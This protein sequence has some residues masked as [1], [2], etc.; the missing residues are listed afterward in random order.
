[1]E[2]RGQKRGEICCPRATHVPIWLVIYAKQHFTWRRGPCNGVVRFHGTATTFTTFQRNQ[3]NVMLISYIKLECY[4]TCLG[5]NGKFCKL[6]IGLKFHVWRV[7]QQLDVEP[8]ILLVINCFDCNN[9]QK[10]SRE[11]QDKKRFISQNNSSSG[12]ALHSARNISCGKT[13]KLLHA[14]WKR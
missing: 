6:K 11:N 5:S 12:F 10:K 3:K 2:R 7:Q 4:D 9:T 14:N 8:A 13:Q 1:M